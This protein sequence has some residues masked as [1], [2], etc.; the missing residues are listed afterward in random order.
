MKSIKPAHADGGRT[1]RRNT[2]RKQS[3]SKVTK[4]AAKPVHPSATTISV[5]ST[6]TP[7]TP[8][9]PITLAADQKPNEQT[10]VSPARPRKQSKA[11]APTQ[12]PVVI[13]CRACGQRDVPL[14]MGGRKYQP[15]TLFSTPDYCC[16]GFCR[17]C[18]ET[19]KAVDQ[20]PAALARQSVRSPT[21]NPMYIPSV[22]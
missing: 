17:I 20:I 16:A 7:S 14:M 9:I 15:H 22:T 1:R 12:T 10:S 3:T 13:A 11:K 21:S 19:G 2:S 8:T 5:T 4:V 18:I 6:A